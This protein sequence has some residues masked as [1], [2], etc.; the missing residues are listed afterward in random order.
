MFSTA[1]EVT[2][3]PFVVLVDDRALQPPENIV[4]LIRTAALDRW[5][6]GVADTLDSL[7]QLLTTKE[8][9]AMNRRIGEGETVE[10]V[11]TEWLRSVGL[12]D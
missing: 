2:A 11:A 12:R 4:P 7:S 5:G 8:L 3:G 6:P 9:Q 10:S 1:P